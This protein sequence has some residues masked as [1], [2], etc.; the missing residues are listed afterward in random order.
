MVDAFTDEQIAKEIGATVRAVQDYRLL[1][2]WR[3]R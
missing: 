3:R 2:G 1:V